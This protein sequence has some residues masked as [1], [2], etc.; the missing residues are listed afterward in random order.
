[1]GK[2]DRNRTCWLR[3]FRFIHMAEVAGIRTIDLNSNSP[4]TAFCPTTELLDNNDLGAVN[5]QTSLFSGD[6]TAARSE[7]RT[8]IC[9]PRHPFPGVESCQSRPYLIKD[10]ELKE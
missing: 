6:R 1:M 7:G 4:E 5:I 8:G 10:V 3:E 9:L 2:F